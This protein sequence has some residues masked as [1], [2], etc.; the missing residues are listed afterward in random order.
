MYIS[1]TN[2]VDLLRSDREGRGWEEEHAM[3]ISFLAEPFLWEEVLS[4]TF[5]YL[6]MFI[7]LIEVSRCSAGRLRV[8]FILCI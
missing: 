5:I 1:L 6:F 8:D 3:Q 4:V 2:K 7:F